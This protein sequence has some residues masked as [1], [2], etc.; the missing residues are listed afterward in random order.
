MGAT[1]GYQSLIAYFPKLEAA[2][3]VGTSLETDTQQH[4][5]DTLCFAYNKAVDVVYGVAHA[6]SFAA[7]SYYGGLARASRFPSSCKF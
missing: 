3:A 2:I 7:G 5:S 4:P 6:C 1:Y